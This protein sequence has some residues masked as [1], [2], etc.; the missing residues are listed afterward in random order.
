[1]QDFFHRHLL[2]VFKW[3]DIE[4]EPKEKIEVMRGEEQPDDKYHERLRMRF[5]R[6]DMIVESPGC[7]P[8][9]GLA[10]LR[11]PGA[12]LSGPLDDRT[13]QQFSEFIHQQEYSHGRPSERRNAS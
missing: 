11:A 2:G 6:Y 13:W 12:A 5:G 1:V 9:L 10:T 7:S 4:F 3:D 8:P